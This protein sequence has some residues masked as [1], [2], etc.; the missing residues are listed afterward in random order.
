MIKFHHKRGIDPETGTI[1]CKGG[2][3]FAYEKIDLDTYWFTVA[4]CHE[5]DNFNKSQGRVKAAG[6]MQSPKHVQTFKGSRDQLIQYFEQ[7]PTS[8]IGNL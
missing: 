5:K 1:S 6:R 3:T 8:I 7:T 2:A 4:R